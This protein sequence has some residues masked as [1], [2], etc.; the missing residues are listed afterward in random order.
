MVI[1]VV[2]LVL[3]K[4]GVVATTDMMWHPLQYAVILNFMLMFFNLIP[5]P[6]LD[7]GA[8]LEGLLPS[9][10]LPAYHRYAVYGPF[11]LMA[12]IL[13]PGMSRIFATP[14]LWVSAHWFNLLGIPHPL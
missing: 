2:L 1:S 9:R 5:A 14:A 6:P 4:N 11:V 3:Y 7:G 8:V 13:V 10:A 12:I